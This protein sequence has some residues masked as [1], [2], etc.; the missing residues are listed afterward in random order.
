MNCSGYG[1]YDTDT[2]VIYTEKALRKSARRSV[3]GACF[4]YLIAFSL[5]YLFVMGYRA[6][7]PFMTS[8]FGKLFGMIT[9]EGTIY[10]ALF[11]ENVA[12]S[13]TVRYFVSMLMSVIC[14]FIPFVLY[15]RF[16][17]KRSFGEIAPMEGKLLKGFLFAYAAS[18][19]MA[20]FASAF[21]SIFGG[22][23]APDLF[24][25][26]GASADF[27]ANNPFELVVVFL[28]LCIL[29]PFVEEFIFRGVIY[30]SLRKFG[31]G[32]AV[33]TSS[34]I[35]GLAHG[36]IEQ[37]AYAFAFGV[38]LAL[39]FEKTGNLKTS[40]L[41]HFLN[42]TLNYVLFVFIP[43]FA[44]DNAAANMTAVV[45]NAVCGVI[46]VVGLVLIF[47]KKKN[48]TDLQGSEEKSETD[49]NVGISNMITFGMLCL[50]AYFAWNVVSTL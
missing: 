17:E 43:Y 28:S 15:G 46:A 8:L 12:S 41:F 42:N 22:F 20:S 9:G 4:M 3:N 26:G 48:G 13:G 35:F 24:S 2:K 34:A 33:V 21:V 50:V 36:S 11:A 27:S 16:V 10:S 40:I 7:L 38:A 31:R 37:M 32:F 19:L 6:V 5:E 14:L 47:S 39:V 44:A 30:G 45:Y 18:Q 25:Q 1:N 49:G 23:V 29:T